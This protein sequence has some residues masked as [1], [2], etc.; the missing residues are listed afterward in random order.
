MADTNV[1][2]PNTYTVKE[3][4][5]NFVIPALNDL[6]EQQT[7]QATTNEERFNKLEAARNRMIGALILITAI[8]IPLSVPVI[9][10]IVQ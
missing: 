8:I 5:A 10:L 1:P 9:S 2:D 7:L 3:M 4:L 6:R